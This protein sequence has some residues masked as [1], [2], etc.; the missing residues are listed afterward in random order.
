[1]KGAI[2][3][4]TAFNIPVFIHWSFGLIVAY[5][6]FT[7]LGE[8]ASVTQSLWAVVTILGLFACVTLHEFGHALAARKYGVGT[9][10][11]VL[12]PIG[13]VARLERLPKK[14][15]Q[16]FV[17]A[18]A[19]PLVNFAIAL[20]ILPYIL[21]VPDALS[22]LLNSGGLAG[23]AGDILPALFFLNIGLGIFN[24]IPAF[25]MDGGRIL[26]ALLAMKLPR[27]RATLFAARVGQ[28][29][30][31]AAVVLGFMG[32]LGPFTAFIGIFIFMM[33]QQEYR[34]VKT[35]DTLKNNYVSEIMRTNFTRFFP[36]EPMYSAVSEIRKGAERSFLVFNQ[37][38]RL[39]GL[40]EE[41]EILRSIKENR[42]TAEVREFMRRDMVAV[43]PDTS[44][45]RLY[46]IL[47]TDLSIVPV[48]E[49]EEVLGLADVQGMN[50]F[51]RM[52]R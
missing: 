33:A 41:K 18:I 20:I 47:Q 24:L 14:P 13:G 29:F 48:M 26:R 43:G 5:V 39:V 15:W 35:E 1:M 51:L 23:S 10:D 17:V 7:S 40:L 50:Y 25:P 28:L 49:G 37:E 19:G 32:I 22:G 31:I 27:V 4:L 45:N 12:Y 9:R 8:G 42:K 44:L 3:I 52:Q 46:E 2:K 16:E 34:F 11:I 6:M 21:F 36:E 38:G 30:G